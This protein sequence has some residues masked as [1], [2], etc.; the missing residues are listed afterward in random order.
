MNPPMSSSD[1][2]PD[3]LRSA[4]EAALRRGAPPEE[5]EEI[6]GN[7]GFA[8]LAAG[9]AEAAI[10][11][12]E[13]AVESMSARLGPDD[14]DT[15]R[16]RGS[17]GRALTE[18]RR[19]D[20]AEAV[21]TAVVDAR[22]RVLGPDDPETLI[23]RG[24]LL[25]A[26]GR[27][28]R[29]LEAVAMADAL[30]ADRLRILG[31]DHPSTL[32]SRGHR[33]QLLG[34]AGRSAEAIEEYER[35]LDDRIRVLGPDHPQVAETRH[36]LAALRSR[37]EESDPDDA[38]WELEQSAVASADRLGPEHPETLV[39]WGLVAEHLQSLGRDS[40]ALPLLDRLL[41]TRGRVLGPEAALTIMSAKMRCGSLRCLG[42]VRVA[43]ETAERL[44]VVAD[45]AF[46]ADSLVAVEIREELISGLR[47]L[48][49]TSP[50]DSPALQRRFDQ[51]I[52]EVAAS[53]SAAADIESMLLMAAEQGAEDG[54]AGDPTGSDSP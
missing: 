27:G 40:E 19:F 30:L 5:L 25:R 36:N 41:E 48:I 33:A 10:E 4:L 47:E 31:P 20:Q 8:L 51:L 32:D 15:L 22:E 53:P 52:D 39:S 9:Y 2:E 37:D 18:A 50:G 16:L 54:P 45:R 13:S 28:G 3:A 43:V 26:V 1:E 17:L 24:N 12:L 34:P 38:L 23:A 14:V 44:R 11:T 49:D 46:G 21:L 6:R 42:Q 7:L 29:S 35:L